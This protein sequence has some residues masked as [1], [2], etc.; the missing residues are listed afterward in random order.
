[1]CTALIKEGVSIPTVLRIMVYNTID[2]ILRIYTLINAIDVKWQVITHISI[3][4]LW[5]INWN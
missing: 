5:N 2:V 1:M 4:N 3:S